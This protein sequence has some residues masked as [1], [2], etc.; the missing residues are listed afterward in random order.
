MIGIGREGQEWI[1]IDHRQGIQVRM[2]KTE[3]KEL[4][5][6]LLID[7]NIIDAVLNDGRFIF[8]IDREFKKAVNNKYS[9]KLINQLRS[10]YVRKRTEGTET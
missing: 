4:C 6:V 8:D 7:L 9:E 10:E 5:R 3:I 1:I 2:N